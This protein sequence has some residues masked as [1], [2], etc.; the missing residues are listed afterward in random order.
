MNRKVEGAANEDG[1][2]PSIW[3]TFTH[4]GQILLFYVDFIIFTIE[5]IVFGL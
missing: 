1:R 2:S 3:D 5:E 4:E